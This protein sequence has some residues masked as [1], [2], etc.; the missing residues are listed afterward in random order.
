MIGVCGIAVQPDYAMRSFIAATH[1]D[2][3]ESPKES[4]LFYVYAGT[5]NHFYFKQAEE[6]NDLKNKKGDKEK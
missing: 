3:I 4:N 1:F 2:V 5:G 6:R